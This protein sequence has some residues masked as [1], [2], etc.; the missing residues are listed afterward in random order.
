MKAKVGDRH[1]TIIICLT[2]PYIFYYG[3]I[4]TCYDHCLP[5][6]MLLLISHAI[7]T[8]SELLVKLISL[9]GYF[10]G[11]YVWKR[12]SYVSEKAYN[13]SISEFLYMSVPSLHRTSTNSDYSMYITFSLQ[14]VMT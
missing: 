9:L 14:C 3:V 6:F 10:Y 7:I 1:A 11:P 8:A 13:Y 12:A 5:T 4:Y 2:P